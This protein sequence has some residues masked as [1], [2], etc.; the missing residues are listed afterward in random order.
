LTGLVDVPEAK[1]TAI[2]VVLHGYAMDAN[3]LAP[4]VVAMGLPAVTYMPRGIHA[5]EP[6]GYCWWPIDQQRRRES[7]SRGP[8]DLCDDHPAGRACARSCVQAVVMHARRRHPAIPLVLAG[9]SQGGMLACDALLQEQVTVDALVLLSSSRIA[10]D[11]WRPRMQRLRGLPV[12]V[13]HGTADSDLAFAAGEGLRDEL[14]A[15]GARVRWQG[16]EGGHEIPFTVWRS[17]RK[18]VQEITQR[19]PGGSIT[20]PR[21]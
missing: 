1:P 19:G 3:H 7:I 15:A 11:E 12:L 5:A 10:L 4:L 9:F 2:L 8:R 21:P 13:A 6:G 17:F 18:F 16:F 14:L 20:L